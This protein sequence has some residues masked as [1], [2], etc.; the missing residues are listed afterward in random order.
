[1]IYGLAID[2]E[3]LKQVHYSINFLR[4]VRF[5]AI[6]VSSPQLDKV[7]GFKY[8]KKDLLEKFNFDDAIAFMKTKKETCI[9]RIQKEDYWFI[10]FF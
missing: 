5:S 2:F 10:I 3:T 7:F 1:M 9:F 8:P 4:I 6:D